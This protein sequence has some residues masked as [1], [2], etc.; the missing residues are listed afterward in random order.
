MN[1]SYFETILGFAILCFAAFFL[2]YS[3]TKAEK[4]TSSDT[5]V[6]KAKFDRVDGITVG[7]E[8]KISGIK[9]GQVVDRVLDNK[10][11]RAILAIAVNNDVKLPSD[12]SAQIL[13]ESLLGQK[14]VSLQPGGDDEMLKEGGEIL[15]TQSSVNLENLI[16]KMMFSKDDKDKKNDKKEHETNPAN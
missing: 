2:F 16:G 7:S 4:T 6:V 14:F 11:Y 3:Y 9:I 8:V 1:R 13:S 10:S 15:Y 5:Y 12:T